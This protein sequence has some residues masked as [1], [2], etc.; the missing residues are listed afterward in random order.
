MSF[1]ACGWEVSELV[2]SQDGGEGKDS[3]V[4]PPF[5]SY[6]LQ[7]GQGR[8]QRGGSTGPSPTSISGFFQELPPLDSN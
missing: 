7:G 2:F 1:S 8:G 3:R 6:L 5:L 4:H